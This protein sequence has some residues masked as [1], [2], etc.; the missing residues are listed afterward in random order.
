MVIIWNY[1]PEPRFCHKSAN[2][3][4][5]LGLLKVLLWSKYLDRK[6]KITST[7]PSIAKEANNTIQNLSWPLRNHWDCLKMGL[8]PLRLLFCTGTIAHSQTHPSIVSS[9]LILFAKT[10]HYI[11]ETSHRNMTNQNSKNVPIKE[12]VIWPIRT[13]KNP[14]ILLFPQHIPLKS[15]KNPWPW[16]VLTNFHG[17]TKELG[18]FGVLSGDDHWLFWHVFFLWM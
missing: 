9:Y 16:P 3:L 11:Q 7:H 1:S 15:Y 12:W 6:C 5:L 4:A 17:K 14:S 8:S 10:K 18:H 2:V 13:Y